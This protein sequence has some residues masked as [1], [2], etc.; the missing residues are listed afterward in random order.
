MTI[1]EFLKQAVG[2]ENLCK[3]ILDREVEVQMHTSD[4][5]YIGNSFAVDRCGYKFSPWHRHKD[6]TKGSLVIDIRIIPKKDE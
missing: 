2:S 6:G 4:G 5:I 1:R 3:D